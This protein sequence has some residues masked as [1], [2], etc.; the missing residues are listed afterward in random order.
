MACHHFKVYDE[1]WQGGDPTCGLRGTGNETMLDLFY[2]QDIAS[3]AWKAFQDCDW[4]LDNNMEWVIEWEMV[5][6]TTDMFAEDTALLGFGSDPCTSGG[7][8]TTGSSRSN[9]RKP[10]PVGWTSLLAIRLPIKTRGS[11]SIRTT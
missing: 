6:D 4:V 9:T 3:A 1:H 2:H 5:D 7:D 8:Q 11:S 10:L